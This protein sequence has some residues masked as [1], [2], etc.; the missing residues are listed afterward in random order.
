MRIMQFMP[1]FGLAGAERMAE[2]LI[3]EL[4]KLGHE[5]MV[6]SLYDFHSSITENLEQHGIRIK[7][8]NKKVGLDYSVVSAIRNEIRSFMPDVIHTHRHLLH[9]VVL[10]RMFSSCNAPIVHTVHNEARKELTDVHRWVSNII[11]L[12]TSAYPVALTDLIK[13]TIY[14]AYRGL[15]DVPVIMNGVNADMVKPVK[16]NYELTNGEFKI[17]H[18]GRFA[19]AKNQAAIVESFEKFHNKYPNSSLTFFGIGEF[20][21]SVKALVDSKNMSDCVIFK[22]VDSKVTTRFHEYD[23]FILPSLYE[24]MPI[25]IIEAMF[26]GMPIIATNV[27]GV[28]NVLTDQEDSILIPVDNDALVSALERLKDDAALRERL[29]RNALKN[30]HKFSG[31]QMAKSYE[32]YYLKL[33]EKNK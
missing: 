5:V 14:E 24:G 29:G 19:E 9:Y 6:I 12:G 22:G 11:F 33:I 4:Q 7:Y 31:E 17:L 16:E 26:A 28:S 25:T 8:M 2:T 21:D 3:L 27:G 15:K 1:E 23:V 10:S 13:D 30:S 18:V 20:F 32:E